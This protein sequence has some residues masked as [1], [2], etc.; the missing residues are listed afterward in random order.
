[1]LVLGS[2][3]LV[4]GSV[5]FFTLIHN[6]AHLNQTSLFKEQQNRI[7]EEDTLTLVPGFIG[8]YPNAFLEV[9]AADVETLVM[10]IEGLRTEADYV[11]M[12]DA[13]GIRRTDRQFWQRSDAF[14]LAHEQSSLYN[15]GI[16]D[17][18]RYSGL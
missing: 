12:R 3:L 14:Q 17:Y 13:W 5:P 18:N 10:A 6:N 9:D 4:F 15:S 2:G 1:M 7:P 8:A 16:L 11:A